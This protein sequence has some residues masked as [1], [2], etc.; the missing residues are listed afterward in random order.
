MTI[1]ISV[2]MMNF[3]ETLLIKYPTTRA[4]CSTSSI[5][6]DPPLRHA[7]RYLQGDPMVGAHCFQILE[8][9]LKAA[10]D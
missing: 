4:H 3:L 2:L 8:L 5:S 10:S 7:L 6:M 1:S 9:M